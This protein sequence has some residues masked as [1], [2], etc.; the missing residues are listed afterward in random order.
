[1]KNDK[2]SA[3]RS[4]YVTMAVLMALRVALHPY[5]PFSA[6]R[7]HE[8]LGQSGEGRRCGLDAGDTRGRRGDTVP[9][10]SLYEVG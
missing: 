2:V 5:L 3:G 6:Q 1:M 10:A 8:L 7:L 4:L 9:A